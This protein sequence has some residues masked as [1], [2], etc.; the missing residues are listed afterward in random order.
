[1]RARQFLTLGAVAVLAACSATT[2]APTVSVENGILIH[3]GLSY[4][5]HTR[6]RL[7]VYRPKN[8][9]GKIPT[10]VFFYGGSWEEGTRDEYAFVGKSLAEMGFLVAIPDYRLY[11]RVKFPA[12]LE[13]GA[14]AV[15]WVSDIA[16]SFGGRRDEI[17][18]MGHSAGAYIA[19]MLAINGK[20]LEGAGA[21][22]SIL[23][24]WAALSGP[25]A[26][27]P[28]QISFVRPIFAGFTDDEVRPISFVNP[29]TPPALLLHGK[30][31]KTVYPDNSTKLAAALKKVGATAEAYIYPNVGH[32]PLIES[33]ASPES[34]IAPAL[35]EISA[36]LKSGKFP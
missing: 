10:I 3:K 1:M 24:R 13:D 36:F 20:Y 2:T 7:D 25:H 11:P 4:G 9:S 5:D 8:A 35:V 23:G 32:M 15:R 31:D 34:R 16:P 22:R 6:H 18:L 33:L 14:Q 27:Y 30:V 29:D 26:F 21:D 17:H 19:S 28:S 12:F